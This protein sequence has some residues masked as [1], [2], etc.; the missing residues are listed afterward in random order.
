MSD[1]TSF[2]QLFE[3][4]RS[5]HPGLRIVHK[6]DSHLMKTI[7]VALKLLSM[8]AFQTFMTHYVTTIG[9]TIYVNDHWDGMTDATKKIILAHE[10]VHITQSKNYGRF[11]YTFLYLFFPI[12]IGYAFYR[13][14]FEMEAYE[15][16][17][18]MASKEYG[19]DYVKSEEYRKGIMNVFMGPEYLWMMLNRKK[20]S[21]WFDRVLKDIS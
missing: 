9:L 12:P 1:N 14:K 16:T 3:H 17:I 6:K 7:D 15:V 8:F 10:E 18:S 2:E 4:Y 11:L 21:D 20:V 19:P 5:I 13:S